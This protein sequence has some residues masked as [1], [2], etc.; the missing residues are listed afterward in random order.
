MEL[1][2]RRV[3]RAWKKNQVQGSAHPNSA[4]LAGF[5]DGSLQG[6]QRDRLIRHLLGCAECSAYA[7]WCLTALQDSVQDAPEVLRRRVKDLAADSR[8]GKAFEIIA[9]IKEKV[10][11]LL[12]TS[13]KVVIGARPK[14]CAVRSIHK[15]ARADE[16][17]IER[18]YKEVVVTVIIECPEEGAF[19]CAVWVKDKSRG[20]CLKNLRVCLY[21]NN[22]EVESYAAVKGRA[23]F[24]HIPLGTYSVVFERSAWPI[25]PVNLAMRAA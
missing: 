19:N 14:P 11:T 23:L 21:K 7:A 8:R 16:L 18:D 6:K 3:Y 10:C 12:H 17:I 13:G 5:I 24:E 1:L 22:K 9:E 20:A 2:I 25:A 15:D 4:V